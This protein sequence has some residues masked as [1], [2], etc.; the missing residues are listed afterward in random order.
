M[1]RVTAQTLADRSVAA[2][3]QA[4][5]AKEIEMPDVDTALSRLDALLVEE[6]R[7]VPHDERVLRDALGLSR[8]G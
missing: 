3:Y 7:Q 2:I 5:G 6:P 4:A 8:A 1:E